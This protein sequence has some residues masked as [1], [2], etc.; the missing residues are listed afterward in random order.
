MDFDKKGLF[1][2]KF[3]TKLGLAIDCWIYYEEGEEMTRDEP[4]EPEIV[5]LRHACVGGID[6]SEIMDDELICLIEE[7]AVKEMMDYED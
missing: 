3:V 5:E 7:K 6:I 2:F 4:G 1:N